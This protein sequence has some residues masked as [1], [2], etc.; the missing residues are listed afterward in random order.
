VTT[1]NTGKAV[2]TVVGID[3]PSV[4]KHTLK[5]RDKSGKL[6]RYGI[7]ELGRAK[8]DGAVADYLASQRRARG[9]VTTDA[10]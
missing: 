3:A 2:F 1:I 9:E 10:R 8:Y 5:V 7:A 6:R 4:G